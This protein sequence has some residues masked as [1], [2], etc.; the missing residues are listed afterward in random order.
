MQIAIMGR[1]TQKVPDYE[2]KK[3]STEIISNQNEHLCSYDIKEAKDSTRYAELKD[4]FLTEIGMFGNVRE[5]IPNS[6]ISITRDKVLSAN[7]FECFVRLFEVKYRCDID[8]VI[9]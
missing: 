3:M 7:M 4:A 5:L 2:Q 9:K 6:T 1:R 8:V